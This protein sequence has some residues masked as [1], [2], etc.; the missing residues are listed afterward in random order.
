[1][2]VLEAT[3]RIRNLL[4]TRHLQRECDRLERALAA[5]IVLLARAEAP[6]DGDAGGGAHD[7]VAHAVHAVAERL[8]LDEA[9]QRRLESAARR[10]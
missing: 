1:V 8:G 7:D 5:A 4:R 10:H 3:L 2:N 6:A 9:Q